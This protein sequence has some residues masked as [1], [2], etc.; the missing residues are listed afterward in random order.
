[1]NTN[2]DDYTGEAAELREPS[3]FVNLHTSVSFKAWQSI[4]DLDS[5]FVGTKDYIG[6][7]FFWD[8]A[9]KWWLRDA[10]PAKRRKIHN[11]ILDAGEIP[12]KEAGMT[13]FRTNDV[14]RS[15]VEKELKV[16]TR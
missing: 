10:T 6:V 16:E 1:M 3:I 12:V 9:V 5:S 15:I 2:A 4:S 13:Y 11:L 7:A 14:V 8:H